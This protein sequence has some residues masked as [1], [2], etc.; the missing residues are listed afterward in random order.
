MYIM[1][2][3]F[4]WTDG[5]LV[6]DMNRNARLVNESLDIFEEAWKTI[7]QCFRLVDDRWVQPRMEREREAQQVYR[8]TQSAKAANAARQ[9]KSS[10]TDDHTPMAKVATAE[11]SQP[12][13]ISPV[14]ASLLP[15]DSDGIAPDTPLVKLASAVEYGPAEARGPS[16]YSS[17]VFVDLPLRGVAESDDADLGGAD[18]SP[19]AD[20][21]SSKPIVPEPPEKSSA[22]QRA[23]GDPWRAAE[24]FLDTALKRELLGGHLGVE[25]ARRKWILRE[26]E[27]AKRLI[28]G[29][30][31]R[32]FRD[33]S[34]RFFAAIAS[35][36]LKVSS[37][38][39]RDLEKAWDFGC[40]LRDSAVPIKPVIDAK[41]SAFA[42]SI[43]RRAA[44]ARTVSEVTP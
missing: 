35:R 43:Q 30:N 33:R 37:A 41:Q 15:S 39:V 42:D 25:P 38:T 5:G 6:N 44:L 16:S 23:D 9:K 2:M 18:D 14:K 32:E 28:S 19:L 1:L 20:T 8:A 36:N 24:W 40:V 7:S 21:T 26:T 29:S 34:Q 13:A 11:A 4:A 27:A 17:S 12:R 31:S 3:S 22:S 10:K